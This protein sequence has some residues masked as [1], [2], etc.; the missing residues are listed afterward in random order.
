MNPFARPSSFTSH[1][2]RRFAWS[3]ILTV[4]AL[5]AC[6]ATQTSTSAA[7]P[8][9]SSSQSIPTPSSVAASLPTLVPTQPAVPTVTAPTTPVQPT[10][11]PAPTDSPTL[12]KSFKGFRLPDTDPC[13]LLAQADVE[14]ALGKPIKTATVMNDQNTGAKGCYYLNDPGK[15]FA[16]LTYW[17]G[18]DAKMQLL[19]NIAQ[20]QQKGCSISGTATTRRVTPTPLPPAVDALKSK[21]L[22]ELFGIHAQLLKGKCPPGTRDFSGLG[23]GALMDPM[24]GTMHIV[25]GEVYLMFLFFDGDLTE[26]K[27]IEGIRLLAASLFK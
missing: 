11:A 21:S 14:K 18:D 23:E 27:E 17:Q 2:E 13:K 9:A 8:P 22:V 4:I 1:T 16:T 19:G 20:I 5:A 12:A 15:S 7:P 6:T 26:Q 3:S 25:A 10:K 24:V